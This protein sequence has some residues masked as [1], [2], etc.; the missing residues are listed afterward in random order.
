[1]SRTKAILARLS[2]SLPGRS[3]PGRVGLLTFVLTVTAVFAAPPPSM[4][5]GSYYWECSYSWV[6]CQTG[7]LV[8]SFSYDMCK[9]APFEGSRS[10]RVCIDYEGDYVYVKDGSSDGWPGLAE[11]V[12]GTGDV[13]RRLCRNTH[14]AGT[15][16]RCN[17]DWSESG[18]K[19]VYGG[20]VYSSASVDTTYLWSFSGA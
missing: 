19:D 17:F 20:I 15:W 12:G 7:V 2:R 4:A 5:D 18:S 9:T 6:T 16:A 8:S 14:T 1:V 10:T 11:I 3:R 13:V